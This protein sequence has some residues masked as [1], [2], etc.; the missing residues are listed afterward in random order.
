M[1]YRL[2]YRT[3]RVWVRS[4]EHRLYK[5]QTPFRAA[6]IGS[7]S[8][9]Q[10]LST[11]FLGVS[12]RQPPSQYLII[13]NSLFNIHYSHLR[14]SP[15]GSPY[16][17]LKTGVCLFLL[18]SGYPYGIFFQTFI[19]FTVLRLLPISTS[20]FPCSIVPPPS[21]TCHPTF[22][23]LEF[24]IPRS[25]RKRNHIPNIRHARYKLHHA[26]KTK[27]KTRMRHRSKTAGI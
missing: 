5:R 1:L 3:G 25:P 16:G 7:G 12:S 20:K 17:A 11:I 15:P 2:S 4:L 6:N 21:N 19:A 18:Q 22:S 13:Q 9:I 14:H 23:H 27:S 24:T 8:L 10:A 26:L